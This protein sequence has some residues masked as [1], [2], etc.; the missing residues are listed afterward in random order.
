MG[1]RREFDEALALE[2]AMRVFWEH[3]YTGASLEDL[4][5][6]MEIARPSLYAC[7]GSKEKLFQRA[8]RHYER[9]RLQV[10]RD[11]LA[12]LSASS[13]AEAVFLGF[14]ELASDPELPLG[15]LGIQAAIAS[16]SRQDPILGFLKARR[17]AYLR[18]LGLR[19]FQLQEG[20]G[21]RR[22]EANA[23]ARYT[24]GIVGALALQ[25]R[26]GDNRRQLRE[27]ADLALKAISYGTGKA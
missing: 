20:H 23:L 13:I 15:F 24:L 17:A 25:A 11:A 18:I 22:G 26:A 5:D 14:V 3:G 10:T 19:F 1:R 7:F 2:A 12:H 9:S 21:L 6:A 16:L 4:T 8:V 27:T